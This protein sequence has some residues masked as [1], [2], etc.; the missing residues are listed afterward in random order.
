LRIPLS[1][2]IEIAGNDKKKSKMQENRGIGGLFIRV[3]AEN[4]SGLRRTFNE[5]IV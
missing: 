1:A 3:P 4:V 2:Q 5:S